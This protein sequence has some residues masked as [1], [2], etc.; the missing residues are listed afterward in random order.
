MYRTQGLNQCQSGSS[1]EARTTSSYQAYRP[2]I[3]TDLTG[4][5]GIRDAVQTRS[6]GGLV[7]GSGD[8]G[9]PFKASRAHNLPL[10][11]LIILVIA[12]P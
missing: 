7:S 6:A 3:V 5:L 1:P 2:P 12:T 4:R 9:I 11:M 8:R 10:S